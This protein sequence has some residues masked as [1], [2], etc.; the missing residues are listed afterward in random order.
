MSRSPRS[1]T[2]STSAGPGRRE[3]FS[4]LAALALLTVVS[5]CGD[6]DSSDSTGRP[7]EAGTTDTFPVTIEHA[8]GE[9]VITEAPERV[10]AWGWA[11]ADA[12]IALG[13]VPVAIP[14]Q[15]Y[16]ADAKGVLP[17]IREALEDQGTEIPTVLPNA[18]E[19]PFEAMANAEPDLILA[20]YSG[21]TES[22]YELLSKIAPTVA[23]PG[24]AW[25]TPWRD[26]ITTVGTA[27]GRSAAA[28][29]LL[30]D[31]DATVDEKAD[32]HPKFDGKSIAMVWDVGGTFYVYR[33]ADPRVEFALALGFVSAPS[34]DALANG[35]S[36]FY[37]TLSYEQLSNLTSDVLVSFADT[38][39]LQETFLASS[40]AQLLP[41]VKAGTVASVVG[42]EFISS[43]SPPTALSLT[44]GIDEYVEILSG[45]A[46]AAE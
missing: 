40:H 16:G 30:E 5:A 17:W 13:V 12:S 34:V 4:V 18:D 35:E 46:K 45:A 33:E 2:G 42:P 19:P 11:S 38:E 24:K 7:D 28:T 3:L 21:I 37:Y 32:A 1:R 9:T 25:S 39:E 26:V 23:Y 8:F 22:D 6:D 10:V 43:V 20:V 27:L 36:T 41:Q 44:W 15:D 31:I 29:T 14:F